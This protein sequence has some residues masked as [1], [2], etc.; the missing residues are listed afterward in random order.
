MEQVHA[1]SAGSDSSSGLEVSMD[2]YGAIPVKAGNNTM[3][4]A[5]VGKNYRFPSDMTSPQGFGSYVRNLEALGPR[6]R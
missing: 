6:C 4:I 3:P 1:G 5:I 2:S